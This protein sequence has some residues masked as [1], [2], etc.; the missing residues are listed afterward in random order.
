MGAVCK[1]GGI[2]HMSAKPPGNKAWCFGNTLAAT[3]LV[4]LINAANLA[5]PSGSGKAASMAVMSLA[6]SVAQFMC[7]VHY[8]TM[9]HEEYHP[10][11]I[12]ML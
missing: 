8:N 10:N 3:I 11:L 12:K 2:A 5:K 1:E 7:I 6:E 4:S 9:L